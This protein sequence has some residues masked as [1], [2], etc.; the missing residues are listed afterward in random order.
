MPRGIAA[1]F[2]ALRAGG[3]DGR[4]EKGGANANLGGVRESVDK[5]MGVWK[6][7]R[8]RGARCLPSGK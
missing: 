3:M 2:A 7:V 4:G 5:E 8:R 6:S 1:F